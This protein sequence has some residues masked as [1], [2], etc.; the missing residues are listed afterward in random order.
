MTIKNDNMHLSGNFA[1]Y[2]SSSNY[3]LLFALLFFSTT[4]A[5]AQEEAKKKGWSLNSNTTSSRDAVDKATTEQ[6]VDTLAAT[7]EGQAQLEEVTQEVLLI[8]QEKVIEQEVTPVV[9][10]DEP[11]ESVEQVAPEVPVKSKSVEIIAQPN[12]VQSA[13]Q[14]YDISEGAGPIDL[15][16][17]NVR[18]VVSLTP[19]LRKSLEL[20]FQE[21]QTLKETE[22][23]YSEQLGESY[24]SYGRGLMQAGRIDESRK[25]LVNAQHIAKINNGVNSIEQRPILRELFEMNLALGNV[26]ETEDHLGRI[27]WLEKKDPSNRDLYSFD[28]VARLGNYYLDLYLDNQNL[29]ELSLSYLNSSIRW[30]SYAI[31]RYG[32]RPLSEVL[33]PYGELALAY[34]MRGR[35]SNEADRSFPQ[36]QNQRQ[37]QLLD[38]E[39]VS[40]V[41]FFSGNS[42]ARSENYLKH[43]LRK[44]KEERD[45]INTVR[46]LLA[47]GDLNILSDRVNSASRYYDL[48]W[49]GAQNLP[50]THPLA[51]SFNAPVRLPSFNFSVVRQPRESDREVEL[52]PLSINVDDDGRV[53]K[54]GREA[55]SEA[56]VSSTTRAR[57]IV[58]R[59]RFRPIIENGK[60]T[61]VKDYHYNVEVTSRRS[62]PK[63]VAAKDSAE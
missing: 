29:S 7:A 22:D 21:I 61:S 38:L 3:L 34:H 37:R 17:I 55:L 26:E 15:P 10:A 62:K 30:L 12:D 11:Q 51:E 52:V 45:L 54:V 19:E 24:L 8:E 31:N 48:A 47:L 36:T 56:S 53:R 42:F 60:L 40:S 63:P 46:A 18:P 2:K 41:S 28:M 49:T 35:I 6:P 50:V 14:E 9:A 13:L 20:Q 59:S 16:P 32:D 4:S 25:M 5:Y 57:R 33:L 39:R 23:A 43:Y 58:K 27:I 44:S 1:V